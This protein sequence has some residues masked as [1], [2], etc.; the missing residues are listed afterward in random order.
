MKE[1]RKVIVISL[2][3]IIL[4]SIFC[5]KMVSADSGWDYSYDSDGSWDSGSSWSSDSWDYYSD[6]YSSSN[7]SINDLIIIVII[8]II[9]F[10]FLYAINKN[11]NQNILYLQK[12]FT[13]QNNYQDLT[14]EEIFKLDPN[15]NTEEL[16]QLTF[17]IY[18]KV[19]EGWMNFDYNILRQYLTDEMYNMYESQLKVLK[20]KH[21]KNMIEDIKFIGAKIID[22]ST[23]NNI[24]KIKVYLQVA[25]KDY[26]V[27]VNNK[28]VRGNKNIRNKM[29]YI[30]TLNK[31]IEKEN[32]KKCPSCGAPI[33][34]VSGGK[35]PYCDSVIHN[36]NDKFVMSKKEC[37]G[38]NRI[39]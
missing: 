32:I 3:L 28:V 22:I 36:Y 18:K 39:N 23:E 6:D 27:D 7:G 5:L 17:D 37:V 19:Q 26:V 4:S 10:I 2:L 9:I 35:C 24:E 13:S 20:A 38:Q 34:I 30:I 25:T 15:I 12:D 16:K 1:N 14:T 31:N 21:Q 11:S 33:D 8:F 29:E